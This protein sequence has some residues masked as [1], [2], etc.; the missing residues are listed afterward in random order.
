MRA[1]ATQALV[2]RGPLTPKRSPTV[3]AAATA[4]GPP[5]GQ[6]RQRRAASASPGAALRA[7]WQA[8][9]AARREGRPL[10]AAEHAALGPLMERVTL[11]D[12]A[13]RQDPRAGSR[14][15]TLAVAEVPSTVSLCCFF[16]P[17]GAVLPLHDHPTMHVTQR[18]LYGA[19]HVR[20]FDW[21]ER[22]EDGSGTVRP[23]CDRPFRPADPCV[24]VTAHG[25]GV[26]HEISASEGPAGFFD[27]ISPPYYS[28]PGRECTYYRIEGAE[29]GELRAVPRRGYHGPEMDTVRP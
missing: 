16:L 25:G 20:S 12:F 17:Q 26:L 14:I 1:A 24:Q 19:V 4:Q 6:P 18:V 13:L 7:V 15:A 22:G 28:A 9:A 23:V 27:V 21:V 5:I 2:R 10:T 3:P 29:R 11:A 8:T